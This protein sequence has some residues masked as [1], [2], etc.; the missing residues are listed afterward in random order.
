MLGTD[1]YFIV[2]DP[3]LNSTFISN[4]TNTNN[5]KNQ[6]QAQS[7]VKQF[8][9]ASRA[10]RILKI[11]R[12]IRLI[13]IIKLYKSAIMARANLTNKTKKVNYKIEEISFEDTPSNNFSKETV[14]NIHNKLDKNPN[15][16]TDKEND[17]N[18]LS[19]EVRSVSISSKIFNLI[20]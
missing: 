1:S 7:A 3:L 16:G 8:S 20:N 15:D 4:N 13:R 6:Q 18:P 5:Q 17:F 9:S 11:I 2:Y 12:I 19:S 14:I 10:T